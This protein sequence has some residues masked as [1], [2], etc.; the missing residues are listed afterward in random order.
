MTVTLTAIRRVQSAEQR[1]HPVIAIILLEIE[2]AAALA[3]PGYWRV[4]DEQAM[5]ALWRE[6]RRALDQE[7]EAY[8][9]Q[10]EPFRVSRES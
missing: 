8:L 10:V 9:A 5:R 2:R 4:P 7:F 3:S 6:R 1:L